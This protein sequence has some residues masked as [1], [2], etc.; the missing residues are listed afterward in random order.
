MID[1]KLHT[2]PGHGI[3]DD[4]PAYQFVEKEYIKADEYDKLIQD[5][6]DFWL[7]S[8][9][10]R[11]AGAFKPLAKLPHLTPFIGI[12]IFY[13]SRFGDPEVQAALKTMMAAGDE[14]VKWQKVVDEIGREALES[15]FPPFAGG[16]SGAPF[17]MLTDMCRGTRG[18]IMD[19]FRQPRKIHEAVERI[20]PIVVN[21]AV[22]AS[23]NAISPVI[24]MPLHKGDNTFMS[25]EQFETFYWPGFR[26][27]LIGL[28]DEGLVPMPF[29]EGNYQPRLNII[30]DMPRAS[31]IWYF[32]HMDMARA[33]AILGD[34]ACIAGNLP[35]SKMVVGTPQE[36]KAG[37]RKLIETCAPGGGYILAASASVE[38]GKAENMRAMLDAAK[39]YGTYRS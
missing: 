37:C 7:R 28:I 24:L 18:I 16:M 35:V 27:V 10:P 22:A 21:E 32:E 23:E 11:M 26:K 29:A 8:F 14:I 20:I 5:P 39:E 17:D 12:P 6:S 2:W 9:M 19:M 15:G 30:K 38:K 36:V 33:K 4:L 31:M 13:L 34:T 25:P 3:G 1:H